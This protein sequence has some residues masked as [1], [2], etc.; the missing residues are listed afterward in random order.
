MCTNFNGSY[1]VLP[2]GTI[3]EI[4]FSKK[5]N[6]GHSGYAMNSMTIDNHEYLY[7]YNIFKEYLTLLGYNRVYKIQITLYI[8]GVKQKPVK[9]CYN[10]YHQPAHD[11]LEWFK[12]KK[13]PRAKKTNK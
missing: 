8:D 4:D 5:R 6:Q 9:G 10:S 7:E 2:I 1:W 11:I 13:Y 12:V 3:L